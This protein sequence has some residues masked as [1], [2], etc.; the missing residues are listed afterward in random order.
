MDQA[1]SVVGLTV[2]V[3]EEDLPLLEDECYYAYQ[4]I[5]FEVITAEG[6]RIGRV[7]DTVTQAGNDLLVVER[8]EREALIPFV[9]AL[10]VDICFNEKKMIVDLPDGL[11]DL[12]EI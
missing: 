11:L 10:C 4:L 1:E 5:G 2:F 3:S 7:K 12:N 8:G 6:E 9:K